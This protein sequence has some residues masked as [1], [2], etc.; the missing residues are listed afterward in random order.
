MVNATRIPEFLTLVC[1]INV[2]KV[3]FTQAKGWRDLRESIDHL[4]DENPQNPL[5]KEKKE[6]L[7]KLES[8]MGKRVVKTLDK[9]EKTCVNELLYLL[10]EHA[11]STV[12]KTDIPSYRAAIEQQFS[13]LHPILCFFKLNKSERRKMNDNY[14]KQ[15][16]ARA[17]ERSLYDVNGYI[18]TAKELLKSD[19]YIDITMGLCALTGRRPGEIL[20]TA[21]FTKT[22]KR[23]IDFDFEK[24][25]VEIKFDEG[26]VFKG[27]MKTKGANDA[28]EQYLI[29]VLCNADW[30]INALDK[31]RKLKDFTG[32]T[33]KQINS[34][35]GKSQNACA[36]KEFSQFFEGDVKPY[37]LRHAYSLICASRFCD[38]ANQY[39]KFYSSI[40]GHRD[41]DNETKDSYM[42]LKLG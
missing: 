37:D 42:T 34:T 24:K 28:K 20:A 14:A 39:G 41:T 40:L 2:E 17:G 13:E 26:V 12:A 10:R 9:L 8:S 11:L 22:S 7:Q 36:K 23:T 25:K 15:V 32:K 35:S 19:S 30:V 16:K 4:I 27:Q 6:A 31:L 5:I 3:N 1:E 33:P 29:P 38:N 18:Q 21:I